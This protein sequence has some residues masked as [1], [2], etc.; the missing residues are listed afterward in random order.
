MTDHYFEAAEEAAEKKGLVVVTPAANELF[1][2]IDS[3]EDA[4]LFDKH[5]KI[6][7]TLVESVRRAPSPSGLP[8]REHITVTLVRNVD[9]PEE[10]IALQAVLGSDRLHEAL[11]LARAFGGAETPTVFFEKPESERTA[12]PETAAAG[13]IA[14]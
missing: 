14:F 7:G 13:D 8:G 3:A 6:F 1:L 4:A 2:D 10:R 5:V 12:A 11:S 9:G